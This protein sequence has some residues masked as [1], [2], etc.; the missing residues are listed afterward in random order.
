MADEVCK[1]S[2]RAMPSS[3]KW[4][5]PLMQPYLVDM[6]RRT[7]EMVHNALGVLNVQMVRRCAALDANDAEWLVANNGNLKDAQDAEVAK[8]RR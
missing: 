2:T 5:N 8:G 1:T 4:R 6:A 3:G 7:T